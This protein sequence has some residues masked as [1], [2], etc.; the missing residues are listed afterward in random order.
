MSSE[1]AN[2][3]PPDSG[4]EDDKRIKKTLVIDTITEKCQSSTHETFQKIENANKKSGGDGSHL[5]AVVLS[6]GCTNY[7][8]KV[9]VN[10]S[11]DICVFA[12]LSFEYALWNPDKSA[13]YDLKRTENE[14]EIMKTVSSENP[15][16]V[17]A[18][19]ACWDIEQEGQKMKLLVTEWSKGDEQFSNQFIDGSVDPR[20]AP[21]LANTLATLHAIKDFDP[22][23]N[24]Q[25]KSC[26]EGVIELAKNRVQEMCDTTHPK[27]RTEGYC[28]VLGAD[29]LMKVMNDNH[30]DYHKRECLVHSDCHVFNILVEAKPSIEKLEAFG[31]DGT[32]VLCDWEMAYAGPMGR[33][34]GLAMSFPIGC[35]VAH[36]LNGHMDAN[37]SINQYISSLLDSYSA[38]MIEAGKTP[39]EMAAITRNAIG[40][41]GCFQFA[42]FYFLN[43]QLFFPVEGEEN[44]KYLIDSMGILGLKLMHLSYDTHHLPTGANEQDIRT[45]FT[46]LVEEEVT[47]TAYKRFAVQKRRMQPR[48][49]SMLRATNRRLSDASM[50][51]AAESVKSSSVRGLSIRDL[52]I[53]ELS[54]R[55]LSISED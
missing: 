47:E 43:V 10:K 16:E 25:V 46:S 34:V 29:V 13:H 42:V 26:V 40:W 2:D 35:M 48:K 6:G 37:K 51:M 24:E 17:V 12:K 30:T 32:V 31:P 36:A 7:S 3:S 41:C 23:F 45:M 55:E 4:F 49:S 54:I 21:K 9:F 11:P 1:D 20:V 22:D 27:D 50:M 15:D 38:R 5:V 8:Y 44:T 52:S 39:E 28:V 33:D 14:Y 53:R 19:L 18:P